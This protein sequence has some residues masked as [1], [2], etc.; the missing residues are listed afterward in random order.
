MLAEDEPDLGALMKDALV[1]MGFEVLLAENGNQALVQQDDFQ[2]DIAFLI[3]DVVMP[4]LNGIQLADLF[5]AIRPDTRIIFLSAFPA[6]GSLSK[7]EVPEG[8]NLLPKP[9]DV[10]RLGQLMHDLLNDNGEVVNTNCGDDESWA[11]S[12]QG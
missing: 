2:D 1:D 9:V 6:N 11:N 7:L 5:S 10:K 12:Y 4:E 8:A 3:T